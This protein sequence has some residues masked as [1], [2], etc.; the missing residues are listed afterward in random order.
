M[1]VAGRFVGEDE[2]RL[3]DDR[4]RD[5][6][7]LLLAAGELAGIEILFPDDGETI[8]R[9]G[10][11]GAALRFAVAAIRE[12]DVEVLVNRQ[13]IEQV[14]VL[15]NETDLLVAQDSALLRFQLMD[16][17]AVEE[18]FAAPAEVVHA[19]Q[20]QQGRFPRARRPHHGDEIAFLDR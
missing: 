4:A 19:E 10:D 1:E 18:I 5:A 16:R 17:G 12:R 14:V 13:V 7:E 11:E 6:D 15:E 8:E 3:G 2:L 20:M 9:V